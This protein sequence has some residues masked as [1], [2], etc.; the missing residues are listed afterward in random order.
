MYF[1]TLKAKSV[2]YLYQEK[3][4]TEEEYFTNKLIN[5]SK[6][7]SNAVLE[8]YCY[9]RFSKFTIFLVIF[10]ERKFINNN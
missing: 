1:F 2:Q 8:V 9:S 7:T 5:E 6:I 3:L 4:K 10:V